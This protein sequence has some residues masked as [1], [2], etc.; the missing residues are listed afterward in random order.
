MIG[1]E[2]VESVVGSPRENAGA[3]I[4]TER[5]DRS[6]RERG[7][8]FAIDLDRVVPPRL[9]EPVAPDRIRRVDLRSRIRQHRP[10]RHEEIE[11]Q[12]VV[13]VVRAATADAV[14]PDVD[15]QERPAARHRNES[16]IRKDL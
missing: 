11:R 5:K 4:R 1:N 3:R 7:D 6:R 2:H 10:T 15:E 14:A 8:F 12:R 9:A 13:V 16:A